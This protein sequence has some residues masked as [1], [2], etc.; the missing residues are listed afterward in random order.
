MM[1]VCLDALKDTARLVSFLFLTYLLMEYLEHRTGEKS[2]AAI[3]KAGKFGPLIG[4]IVGAFPQ[5]GFSAAASGLYSGGVI[6]PGTLL[7]IF[8][9]TSDEMLPIFISESVSPMFI[10][11]ILGVKIVIGTITGFALDYLWKSRGTHDI[12][13]LCEHEHCHCEEGSI[14]R[15]ALRHTMQI[16]FFIFMISFAI[17][18][19]MEG[20]GHDRIAG[21]LGSQPIIG[22]CLAALIGM[23]P[24]CAASVIITELYLSGILG[25]GQMLAGLLAGAGVGIL[26]LFKTNRNRRE[27]MKIAGLL[28]MTSVIWGILCEVSGI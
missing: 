4:G 17:G 5:C 13:G 27:N 3:E 21:I 12:H 16:T 9:S 18:I 26:I 28:Y 15:S 22:V 25:I 19:L 20:I 10:L 1:D 24:N 8:L 23:I 11:K 7:A 14:L 6:S 2:K